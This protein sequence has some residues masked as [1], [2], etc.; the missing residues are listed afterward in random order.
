MIPLSYSYI[1]E[2]D[3]NKPLLSIIP[4]IRDIYHEYKYYNYNAISKNEI[5]PLINKLNNRLNNKLYN[6]LYNKWSINNSIIFINK[7]NNYWD[8]C[9]SHIR[10]KVHT[11]IIYVNKEIDE[12]ELESN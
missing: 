1:N 10:H 9:F 5:I 12:L 8:L 4:Y 2:Y 6:K 11:L 7:S 3:N